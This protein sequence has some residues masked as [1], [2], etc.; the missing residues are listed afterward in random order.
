[1]ARK[2]A[3]TISVEDQRRLD[4][5][6]EGYAKSAYHQFAQ[7]SAQHA[8]LLDRLD[9][10]KFDKDGR[11]PDKSRDDF[12]RLVAKIDRTRSQM[13]RAFDNAMA[14]LNRTIHVGEEEIANVV[15]QALM[16]SADAMPDK[17]QQ[18]TGLERG[19][20][21]WKISAQVVDL[22][23]AE[24]VQIVEEPSGTPFCARCTEEILGA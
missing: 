3:L 9:D 2:K 22:F 13:F 24:K 23:K 19:R 7:L 6:S 5:M 15:Y 10:P 16:E 4:E 11:I 18:M 21:F 12:N 1:M 17:Y 20:E 14:S 8:I